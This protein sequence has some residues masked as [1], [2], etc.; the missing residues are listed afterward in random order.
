MTRVTITPTR[1]EWGAR[2]LIGLAGL[3]VRQLRRRA[4]PKR[5]GVIHGPSGDVIHRFEIPPEEDG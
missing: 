5:C 1:L 2:S 3:M 4:N